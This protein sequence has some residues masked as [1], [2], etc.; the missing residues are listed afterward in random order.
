[1]YW[2]LYALFNGSSEQINL[3]IETLDI[4]Q[5]LIDTYGDISPIMVFGD[6]NAV[7]PH[8]ES[9]PQNWYR[10]VDLLWLKYRFSWC[11]T[12][13]GH[14]RI[15]CKKEVTCDKVSKFI[16]DSS[17][18]VLDIKYVSSDEDRDCC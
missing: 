13:F 17:I 5:D 1:M 16:E 9:L 15:R 12:E 18:D 11:S 10:I 8:Y 6:F 4:I 3:Y 14:F 7:L 2:C